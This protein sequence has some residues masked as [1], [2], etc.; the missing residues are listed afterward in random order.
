MVHREEGDV[1][2]PDNSQSARR[3]PSGWGVDMGRQQQHHNIARI[4]AGRL[5]TAPHPAPRIPRHLQ[6]DDETTKHSSNKR[7]SIVQ[8]DEEGSRWRNQ[9][10]S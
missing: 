9:S 6:L 5:L 10:C 7:K 4:N 8:R 2:L 1:E 3:C